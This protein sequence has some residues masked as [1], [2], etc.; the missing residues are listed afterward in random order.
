MNMSA[1]KNV[2]RMTK[3]GRTATVEGIM[4]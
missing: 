4:W 1:Q 3:N 2:H